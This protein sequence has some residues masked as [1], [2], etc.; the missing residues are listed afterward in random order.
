[1]INDLRWVCWHC[2]LYFCPL[3]RKALCSPAL[4]RG[5]MDTWQLLKPEWKGGPVNM[6][7]RVAVH[8]LEP[9]VIPAFE[10]LTQSQEKQISGTRVLFLCK[11]PINNA[12]GRWNSLFT[13]KKSC[14]SCPS[15]S[16]GLGHQRDKGHLWW[17]V[18]KLNMCKFT[19]RPRTNPSLCKCC[20]APFFW[21]AQGLRKPAQ[22]T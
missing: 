8:L 9:S 18:W 2:W 6:V 5:L 16:Q 17:A 3:K 21:G 13:L 4:R 7:S 14:T 12:S 19:P 1:M 11:M 20:N 10:Y 22:K 15:V